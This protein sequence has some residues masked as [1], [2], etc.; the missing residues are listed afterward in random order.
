MTLIFSR[1]LSFHITAA[2][3][4]GG[5]QNY[6]DRFPKLHIRSLIIHVNG[7]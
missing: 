1:F 7:A 3:L 4:K 6:I 2:V 5:T